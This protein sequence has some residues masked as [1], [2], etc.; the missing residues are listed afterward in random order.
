[1]KPGD[2]G[3]I[4][5]GSGVCGAP[6]IGLG[7]TTAMR[8][9]SGL[10]PLAAPLVGVLVYGL[11]EARLLRQKKNMTAMVHMAKTVETIMAA[12][13]LGEIAPELG[14]AVAMEVEV[15]VLWSETEVGSVEAAEVEIGVM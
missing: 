3:S 11:W 13:I 15:G 2:P 12:R 10:S 4:Y 8:E 9:V 6:G 7:G 1:M 5:D 14:L